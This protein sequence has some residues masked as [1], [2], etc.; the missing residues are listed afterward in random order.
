[1]N[2]TIIDIPRLF[3]RG[4]V[5]NWRPDWRGQP[6]AVGTDGSEQIVYN[7]FPRFVGTLQPHIRPEMIAAWRAIILQGEGR[8]NA[9]RVRMI[10]PA[11]SPPVAG[12]DWRSDLRAYLAGIYVEPRPQI[13]CPAGATA[14]ATSIVVDER[15]A[16]RPVKVG[17]FLSHDDWPFA[18]TARSGSGEVTTLSVKMLRRPIPAGAAID[19]FAR[20]I[21]IAT[22]DAMGFPEYGLSRSARP[23]LDL[24][25]WITR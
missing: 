5:R 22:S 21:F 2:R 14:G 15:L 18:V 23:Q 3:C 7:R 9:Y 12:G 6:P 16:P 20:G 19:L 1:V 17:A 10:D 11:G 25:E 24:Q 4:F 8:V 13:I